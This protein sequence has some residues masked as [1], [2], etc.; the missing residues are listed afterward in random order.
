VP[1]SAHFAYYDLKPAR[2]SF[3]E[4]VLRGLSLERKALPPKYFYD[5]RGSDFFEAICEQ[6]EYYLTRTELAMLA[7]SAGEIAQLAGEC[8]VVE[9]G[10]GS[11][12]KTQILLEALAPRA[13]L[14]IDIA[15]EQLRSAMRALARKF[16]GVR[17]AGVCADYSAPL[18]LPL[19]EELGEGRRLVFFPG[20]TIGNFLPQEALEFLRMTRRV[21]GSLGA[22]LIGVDLEKDARVL[23]AA[24][25]DAAGVTAAFNLNLLERINRELGADFDVAAYTHRAFYN[26]DERRIEM[27]LVSARDQEVRLA[28]HTF[29]FRAGE[30][31]HTESS[32]KYSV[33]AFQALAHAGGFAS[34][35]CW[36]DSKGLFSIHLL[37]AS[38]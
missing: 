19:R 14:A 29:R 24:Y 36:T 12:R 30:T 10:T 38:A 6:P 25:N 16:P 22:L 23:N 8:S 18:G 2:D 5:E 28:G 32:Y 15:C 9:F 11:G 33:D 34:R 13:Y 17:V 27:H 7:G 26:A 31:L 3:L 1:D 4:D 21:A 37:E 35:R 20:S